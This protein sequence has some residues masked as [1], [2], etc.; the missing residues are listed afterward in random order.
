MER[1]KTSLNTGLT[2]EEVIARVAAG[3]ANG[4]GEDLSKSYKQ[5]FKEN[6]LTAFNFLNL[7]LAIAVLSVGSYKNALFMGVILC[8]I[9]IGTVQEI[10]AK[11]TIDRLSLIASPKAHVLRGGFPVELPL[12]ELVLDDLLC[13]TAGSQICADCTVAEG[14]CEVNESLLTGE[15]DAVTKHPGDTLLSGSFVV[16]GKCKAQVI[17]VGAE[18]Y[19]AQITKTAKYIKHPASQLMAATHKIIKFIALAIIPIGIALFAKQVFF[20]GLPYHDAVVSTVG[21]LVGMIPE[22]LVLLTSVVLAVSVMR[23]ASHHALVQELFSIEMLARVDVLCLDKT[24]TITEGCMEVSQ[25]K[26]LGE[27]TLD[28][29]ETILSRLLYA[30]GDENPTAAALME[31]YP[32]QDVETTQTVPFSSA[33]KW[34]G[35]TFQGEGSYVLGAGEFVLGEAFESLREETERAAADGQRVLVLAHSEGDFA[36]DDGLPAGL[37]PQALIFITDKIRPSA[38]KTLSYFREQG[39]ALKVI[40]GDNALTVSAVAKRAGLEGAENYV[41][42]TTLKTHE[43]V[44]ATAEQYTVFGRVTPEQKLWLIQALKAEGHTVAMTGDGVNDVMA[45]KESDCSIA[46]ASGSDAARTVSQIVLLDSDFASMPQIVAEGRRSINNLQRSAA[47]FLTKT[48]F[49]TILALCFLFIA[50]RYPFQPIQLTLI[51]VVTIG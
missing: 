1:E 13:L 29:V 3:Q 15:A 34:S 33:R 35:A 10:R 9:V 19:A 45:L 28:Q 41:D 38:P 12:A 49:S 39:V 16:S 24:G 14:F 32:K 4:G 17:H 25:V 43:E 5:I 7:V 37:I 48:I 8:N 36:E 46:M 27:S 11:R 26:P 30:V 51:S 47:L 2:P 44:A 23:L 22:G 20:S 50:G 6:L 21:A 18:N 42:A 40:S 31:R